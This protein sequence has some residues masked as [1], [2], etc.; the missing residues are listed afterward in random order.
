MSPDTLEKVLERLATTDKTTLVYA[1][2]PDGKI[3][4][5]SG[6]WEGEEVEVRNA[7]GRVQVA[8][9]ALHHDD[10]NPPIEP[11]DPCGLGELAEGAIIEP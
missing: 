6:S 2:H 7:D 8:R 4:A 1:T 11:Y 10:W 5:T 3:R 9:K